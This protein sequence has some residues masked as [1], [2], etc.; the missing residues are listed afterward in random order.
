MKI[1]VKDN[2]GVEE[3]CITLE[4]CFDFEA[5]RDCLTDMRQRPWSG[6]GRIIF[7]LRYVDHLESAGLGAM[8]L[9]VERMPSR[10]R[11]AIRCSA[12]K[13]WAVL[14]VARLDRHFD[15]IPEGRL[16]MHAASCVA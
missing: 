15:L 9:L 4:G 16:R 6:K 1:S 12:P 13:V 2:Q 11:P 10:V 7:D 5:A 14:K 3:W 8:L